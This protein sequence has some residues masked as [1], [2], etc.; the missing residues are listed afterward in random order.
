MLGTRGADSILAKGGTDGANG[1]GGSDLVH[2]GPGSDSPG[3]SPSGHDPRYHL[4]GGPGHDTVNGGPG[5]DSVTDEYGPSTG[6]V[7]DVD[8]LYVARG[9][10]FLNARD[11]DNHDYLDCGAG[12]NMYE[13]DLGDTVL[14]NCQKNVGV[15]NPRSSSLRVSS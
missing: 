9:N 5:A 7:T 10:D 8:V 6:N 2:G 14:A 15:Q 1:R 4:E 11:G 13:A 12:R 3:N